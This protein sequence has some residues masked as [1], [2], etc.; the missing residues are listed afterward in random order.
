MMADDVHAGSDGTLEVPLC[1]VFRR[2]LRSLD[3]KY[4]QERADI[5]AAVMSR[6]G[7][8]DPD[9]LGAEMRRG[10]HDASR[11]TIYRTLRLLQDAGIIVP[12][13]ASDSA[14]TRY[15]VAWGRTPRNTIVCARTGE[16][17][18]FDSPA[19]IALRDEMCRRHGMSAVGHRFMVYAVPRSSSASASAGGP[20][21]MR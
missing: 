15:E 13:P 3:L 18:D 11:A 17:I 10:G 19:L 4:T 14:Q 8:F 21:G 16:T 12:V 6:E 2:H 9:E 5:L 7:S 20:P 1:S